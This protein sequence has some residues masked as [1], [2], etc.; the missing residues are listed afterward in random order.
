MYKIV[1]IKD[2]SGKSFFMKFSFIRLDAQQMTILS[3]GLGNDVIN[4]TSNGADLTLTSKLGLGAI[5]S[6]LK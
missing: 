6:R 2:I 1:D 3:L 5:L 4:V